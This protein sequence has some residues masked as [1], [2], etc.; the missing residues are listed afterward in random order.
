[1]VVVI[2]STTAAVSTSRTAVGMWRSTPAMSVAVAM[3][4]TVNAGNMNRRY[5]H[6]SKT[7]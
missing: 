3:M 5:V 6:D 1:L 7:A 2:A 4:A